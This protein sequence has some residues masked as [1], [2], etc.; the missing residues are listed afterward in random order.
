MSGTPPQGA[1]VKAGAWRVAS[2]R[3]PDP[4]T[5]GARCLVS[6]VTMDPSHV[7]HHTRMQGAP[8]LVG[9]WGTPSL[10]V[11]AKRRLRGGGAAGACTT[12]SG[13][14]NFAEVVQRGPA[15]LKAAVATQTSFPDNGKPLQSPTPKLKIQLPGQALSAG[16]P[17]PTW[18]ETWTTRFRPRPDPAEEVLDVPGRDPPTFTLSTSF[19]I[20]GAAVWMVTFKT[21][22][23]KLCM[24]S[25][26][27]LEVR[28]T[29]CIVVDPEN[30]DLRMKSHWL[31]FHVLGETVRRAIE[32]FGKVQDLTRGKWK[33]EGFTGVQSTTTLRDN[34]VS[35]YATVTQEGVADGDG[36]LNIDEE[37]AEEAAREV[38]TE[39]SVTASAKE[40]SVDVLKEVHPPRLLSEGDAMKPDFSQTSSSSPVVSSDV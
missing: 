5:L 33:A 9:A 28:G 7:G 36:V 31:L 8:T 22:K 35:T 1:P 30:A 16:L 27:E 6:S 15:P 18:S 14:G 37:E 19:D 21:E 13:S 3:T 11:L 40:A 24:V 10:C 12:E 26:K 2:P 17:V 39:V 23:A 20:D 32:P 34:C 29:C 25:A 38:E 4:C